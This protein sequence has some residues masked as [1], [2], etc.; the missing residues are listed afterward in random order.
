MGI[1]SIPE[2]LYEIMKKYAK[3]NW[4]EVA[5]R[6]IIREALAIKGREEG[7]SKEEFEILLKASGVEISRMTQMD[8]ELHEKVLERE[9]RREKLIRS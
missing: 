7:L 4:S 9:R 2:W 8:E 6:A 5:R 1:L 3:V